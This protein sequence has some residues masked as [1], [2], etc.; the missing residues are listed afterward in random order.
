MTVALTL[1]VGGYVAFVLGLAW[2]TGRPPDAVPRVPEADLPTVAIVVAARDEEATIARCLDALLAQDYPPERLQIVVADDHSADRTAA[3]VRRYGSRPV[4][5]FAGDLDDFDPEAD[6]PSVRC[7]R[8]PDPSGTL[9]GKANALHAA[10]MATDAEVVLIT[11]A[12]CAPSPT[13]VLTMASRFADP[14]VGIVCGMARIEA[15]HGRPFDR[16][17]ALDWTFL[18]GAM[19]A[20][21]EA[22]A[23]AT[24]M[25]NNMAVRRAAYDAVGGYPALPF[26]LTEDFTL[27]RSIADRTPWHVRFPLDEAT[28][29]WTLPASSVGHAYDQRRRWARGGL[30]GGPWVLGAY[31]ALFAVHAAPVVGLLTAPAV[32]LVALV[33]KGLA[34]GVLL[35]AVLRRL[36]NRLGWR[37]L[38]GFEGFLF[39]YL[40]TLPVVLALRPR[41]AWK[42]RQH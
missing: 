24:A 35:R 37:D 32:A 9:R 6:G 13:W 12:D 18:L 1:V 42:G 31:T 5:V 3:V 36:G 7:V 38:V 30:T 39:G 26:S 28:T 16:V 34:D 2:R 21:A 25:G 4:P 19:S 33:A 23:P 8:V 14:G 15:Q 40:L 27:V 29:V 10:I 41:V 17:Q 11:D 22:G 20:L